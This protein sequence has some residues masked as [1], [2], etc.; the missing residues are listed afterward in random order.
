MPRSNPRLP[1]PD[2][3]KELLRYAGLSTEVFASVGVS[4]FLGVKADK[5]LHVPFP[6]LAW[7]LPLLVILLLIIKLLKETSKR[8]NG[9]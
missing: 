9:N 2:R 5:W 6:V 3:R 7:L 4:V 8:K 1:P